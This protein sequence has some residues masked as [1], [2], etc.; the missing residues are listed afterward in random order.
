VIVDLSGLV[1]ADISLMADLA[2]VSRRLR[3]SGR[4][5]FLRGA[6]PQIVAVIETFGLHRLPGVRL[7]GPMPA[8]A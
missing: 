1:Y 4:A 6:T 3:R 2:M 5:L 8:L 7:D